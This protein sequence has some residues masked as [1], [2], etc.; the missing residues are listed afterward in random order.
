[1]ARRRAPRCSRAGTR[2]TKVNGPDLLTNRR[3]KRGHTARAHGNLRM[4]ASGMVELG[5]LIENL[6]ATVPRCCPRILC[7]HK[8]HSVASDQVIVLHFA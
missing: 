1:M 4:R 5:L 8:Q 2:P 6:G 7:L 3:I